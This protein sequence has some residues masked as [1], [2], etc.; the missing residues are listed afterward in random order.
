VLILASVS[1][2]RADLLRAAGIPAEIRPAN[3]DE[4]IRPGETPEG[5]ACRVARDKALAISAHAPGRA[6]LAADT[7][8]VVDG[9]ILGKPA[10]HED[11]RRM[12]RLL[13]G[14]R[15]AVITAVALVGS[16][17]APDVSVDTRFET[18]TVEFAALSDAEI[19]WYIATREPLDKAGGYA[20]QGLASRFVTRVEGSYSNVVGLPI[21]LVYQMCTKAGLLLS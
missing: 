1:P 2:R 21:S 15:H 3:V 9:L 18:T 14:R 7:V 11:A 10:D 16:A 5:Y 8:V 19:E 17:G 4:S 13:S 20:I 12:L 6:V